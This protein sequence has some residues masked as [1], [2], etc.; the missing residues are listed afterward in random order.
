MKTAFRLV[1][2]LAAVAVFGAAV[3]GYLGWQR[4]KQPGPLTEAATVIVEPGDGPRRIA[5]RLAAAGVIEHPTL[6]LAA[7]R[8]TERGGRLQ[9]GEFRFEPGVSMERAIADIAAG[10]TVVRSITIPEGLTSAEIARLIDG[11]PAMAGEAPV[12]PEGALL[13]ETYHYSYGDSRAAMIERMKAARDAALEELWPERAEN[14]P[15]G[16][17]REAVVLA[18]IVEKET[19]VAG[20]R[21][22][23]AAV[24]V[25]RLRK[26]MRLQSDPTVIYALTKGRRELGRPLTRKD[27]KVDSPYNT[28]AVAG[29]PP[30]AIANPGRAALKAALNPSQTNELY[31]VAD[32]SGGHAFART[33]AEHNRNVKRWRKLQKGQE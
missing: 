6:F 27:L 26:G 11:A 25:N 29:L 21:R 24:F 14:L 13:P 16:S 9:A 15:I 33:L 18:S 5:A 1:L 19:G 20:E 31:F 23:V 32:G 17:P 28:Y 7:V 22:R 4:Y 10:R 8:L 30:T 12:A 3:A 2:V